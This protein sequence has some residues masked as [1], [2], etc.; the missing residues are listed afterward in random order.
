MVNWTDEPK[1][2][3]WSTDISFTREAGAIGVIVALTTKAG[4][5]RNP[6]G[7]TTNRQTKDIKNNTGSIEFKKSNNSGVPYDRETLEGKG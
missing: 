5:Q 1:T 4:K 3:A 6:V 7:K 2:R